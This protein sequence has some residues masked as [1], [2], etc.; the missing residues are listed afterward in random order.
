MT[1]CAS[2]LILIEYLSRAPFTK[3]HGI[4]WANFV[5]IC[6]NIEG[7]HEQVTPVPLPLHAVKL[8][9]SDMWSAVLV[10]S[11][12]LDTSCKKGAKKKKKKKPSYIY[13]RRK[14]ILI[15]LPHS[16]DSRASVQAL[17]W[18]LQLIFLYCAPR[19]C[20]ICCF[21]LCTWV[22]MSPLIP[23]STCFIPIYIF[24]LV[25]YMSIENISFCYYSC[26]VGVL[27]CFWH[28]ILHT[29]F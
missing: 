22:P 12:G 2:C 13:A 6:L 8:T 27:T 20:S 5:Q 7:L 19:S 24:L 25:T 18:S 3:A 15:E 4:G 10:V 29:D 16:P 1:S 21:F 9:T 28:T 17:P 14:C 23:Q 26:F 11:L